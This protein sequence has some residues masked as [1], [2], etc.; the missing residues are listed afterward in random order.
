M[1]ESVVAQKSNT[2]KVLMNF[3]L[4]E[5]QLQLQVALDIEKIERNV[6]IN[7]AQEPDTLS[8]DSWKIVRDGFGKIQRGES[9]LNYNIMRRILCCFVPV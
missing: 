5:F 4:K 6:K 7:H 2:L 3:N 9:Y 1:D 8:I